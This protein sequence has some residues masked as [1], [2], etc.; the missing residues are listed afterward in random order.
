[1][2]KFGMQFGVLPRIR[3]VDAG[4][5]RNKPRFGMRYEASSCELPEAYS[6][7]LSGVRNDDN[8]VGRPKS[9]FIRRVPD[10]LFSMDCALFFEE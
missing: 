3:V 5:E 9:W 6:Y 1:M 4:R 10:E 8:E 2:M 7:T